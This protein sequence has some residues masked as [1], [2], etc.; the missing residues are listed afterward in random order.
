MRDLFQA[1]FELKKREVEV[2][3]QNIEQHHAKYG[4]SLFLDSVPAA[5][6]V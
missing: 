6:K 2:A 5:S 1:V 3:R 4:S